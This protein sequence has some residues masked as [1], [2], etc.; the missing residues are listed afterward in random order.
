MIRF[1]L[2]A[3]TLSGCAITWNKPNFNEAEFYRDTYECERDVAWT[4]GLG[5]IPAGRMYKRCMG[6]KGYVQQ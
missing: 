3:L 2:L 1:A 6:S 5:P 4:N